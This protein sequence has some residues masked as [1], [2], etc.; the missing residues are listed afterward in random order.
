MD[1]LLGRQSNLGKPTPAEIRNLAKESVQET[2]A[3]DYLRQLMAAKSDD[4]R[5]RLHTDWEAKMTARKEALNSSARQ[6]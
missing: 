6:I 2:G 5:Q 4:E 1:W 3:V